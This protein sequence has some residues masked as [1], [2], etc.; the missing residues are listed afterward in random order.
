MKASNNSLKI[1]YFSQGE[2]LVTACVHPITIH[3]VYLYVDLAFSF[4]FLLI[5]VYFAYCFV[6]HFLTVQ[7][8]TLQRYPYEHIELSQS[9]SLW[10]HGDQCHKCITIQCVHLLIYI[11]ILNF[12]LTM[13]KMLGK[14]F[15]FPI[16][17]VLFHLFICKSSWHMNRDSTYI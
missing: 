9:L 12:I 16:A 13:T 11:Q 14:K 10:I 1:S 4:C 8:Y 5:R 3:F 2:P 17:T 7:Q 15:F 6:S